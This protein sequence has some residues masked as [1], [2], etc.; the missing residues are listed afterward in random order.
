[1][2]I[3]GADAVVAALGL[4]VASGTD[5]SVGAHEVGAGA[6]VPVAARL[7]LAAWVVPGLFTLALAVTGTGSGRVVFAALTVLGAALLV[8]VL[9]NLA[10]EL[11]GDRGLDRVDLPVTP[12]RPAPTVAASRAH[13][14]L[15]LLSPG[16]DWLVGRDEHGREVW[17]PGP[18]L[19][20]VRTARIRGAWLAFEDAEGAALQRLW[21]PAWGDDARLRVGLRELA[22]RGYNVVDDPRPEPTGTLWRPPPRP[23]AALP[24]QRDGRPGTSFP[25]ASTAVFVAIALVSAALDGAVSPLAAGPPVLALASASVAA[26]RGLRRVRDARPR[27]PDR[28]TPVLQDGSS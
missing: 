16:R 14:R 2:R 4:R 21:W 25:A 3:S 27:S 28:L 10:L 7:L 15:S 20:G 19:G 23:G 26:G 6:R 9:T 22:A 13:V 17:T 1:M 24:R 8:S 12:W 5:V 18:G 11:A